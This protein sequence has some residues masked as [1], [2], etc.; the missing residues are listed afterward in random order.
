MKK[1]IIVALMAAGLTACAQSPAPKEDSK[2][3]DAY[4]ACINT[5]EG[6]PDKIQAC[7]SVLNVLK[8]EKAHEQFANQES[9]RVIDYQKCINARKMGNDEAVAK[10]CDK[11]WQEIRSNN[12][13]QK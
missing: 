9:V 12:T 13:P 4:S 5:A 3:K 11:I 6:N 8:Q 7:Q 2:L 1:L 10:N